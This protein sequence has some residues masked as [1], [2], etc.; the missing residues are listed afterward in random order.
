ME[1]QYSSSWWVSFSSREKIWGSRKAGP[2]PCVLFQVSCKH[3]SGRTGEILRL[4]TDVRTENQK[5]FCPDWS[6][7]WSHVVPPSPGTHCVK[8]RRKMHRS[9]HTTHHTLPTQ[10]GIRRAPT[11]HVDFRLSQ[12]PWTC[13]VIPGLCL[14][15]ANPTSPDPDLRIVLCA[16]HW[17]CFIT[18]FAW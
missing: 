14:A 15:L 6:E 12:S 2:M 8:E 5:S 17:T 7:L 11:S 4:F 3:S 9:T 13:M 16:W 18:M 1:K 10:K